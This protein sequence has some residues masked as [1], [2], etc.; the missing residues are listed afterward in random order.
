V[1]VRKPRRRAKTC[2]VTLI[3][4]REFRKYLA[5]Q[6]NDPDTIDHLVKRIPSYLGMSHEGE[7]VW[8]LAQLREGLLRIQRVEEAKRDI[9]KALGEEE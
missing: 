2:N 6:G 5:E 7:K 9:K 3:P 1:S 8:T 4:E